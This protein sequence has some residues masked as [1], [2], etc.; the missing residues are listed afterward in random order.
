[1]P[2]KRE[3][4]LREAPT[5]EVSIGGAAY[6]ARLGDMT[7]ALLAREALGRL[8]AVF[9]EGLGA[10]DMLDRAEAFS[11]AARACVASV[12]GDVAAEEL[13]GGAHRLD[14]WRVSG[15]LSAVCDV[16]SSDEYRSATLEAWGGLA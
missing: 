16:V 2:D 10:E 4:E 1:M 14:M 7:F 13:V 6:E 8:G 11:E 9:E 5:M 12:L 15:V 3:Y